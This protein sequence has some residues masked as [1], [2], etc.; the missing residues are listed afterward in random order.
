VSGGLRSIAGIDAF[1]SLS[2]AEIENVHPMVS[3]A[4][5]L[6]GGRRA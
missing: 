6:C 4:V 3:P 1:C 2:G 5:G